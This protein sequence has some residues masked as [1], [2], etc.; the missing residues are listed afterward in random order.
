MSNRLRIPALAALATLAACEPAQDVR[1]QPLPPLERPS[2]EARAGLPE[3][4]GVW[5][6][7]G[8]DLAPQDSASL[9]RDLPGLGEL[10]LQTQRL[11]S[12]AGAYVGAGGQ[13]PLVGEVRRDSVISLV[14]SAG[15]GVGYFL[16]GEIARDTL[17]IR[18]SSLVEPG[19]WP[20]EAQ[21]A[22]V[23]TQVA[24]PFVRLHGTTPAPPVD[25][26]A[27]LAADSARVADSLVVA[28][29]P[30]PAAAAD[31]AVRV[32]NVPPSA[33]IARGNRD[34]FGFPIRSAAAA[35]PP[36]AGPRVLGEPV[37]RDQPEPEE[38]PA[39][40]PRPQQAAPPEQQPPP[41]PDEPPVI[42]P[43][44]RLPPLLGDPVPRDTADV[45]PR[46]PRA[47]EADRGR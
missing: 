24:S 15:G 36:Q 35:P 27:L 10:R 17:W 34:A 40:R 25:S 6:F 38:P 21:A 46:S 29:A 4:A 30:P 3:V 5:R 14:A 37:E 33:F 13:L 22:F 19:V 23:R 42:P 7:A 43:A 16:A 31:S 8:W 20:A 45:T 9:Q 39:P 44:P 1:V 41:E 11:D 28:A 12:I 2:A 47:P 32:A 18:L 26:A